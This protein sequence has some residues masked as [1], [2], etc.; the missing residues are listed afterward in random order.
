[1]TFFCI[2]LYAVRETVELKVKNLVCTGSP[3]WCLKIYTRIYIYVY[4]ASKLSESTDIWLGV[5]AVR[6]KLHMAFGRIP[7]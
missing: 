7:E 2:V 5:L 1:M 3:R 4:I 6:T